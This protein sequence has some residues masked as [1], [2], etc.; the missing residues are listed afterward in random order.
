MWVLNLKFLFKFSS[1]AR[2]H[3]KFATETRPDGQAKE[4]N[5]LLI[6]YIFEFCCLRILASNNSDNL[7]STRNNNFYCLLRILKF[8][9]KILIKIYDKLLKLIEQLIFN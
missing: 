3:K 5:K 4:C 7:L 8:D 2:L 1:R 6:N 9:K